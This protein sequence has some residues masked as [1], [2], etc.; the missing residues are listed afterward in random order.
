MKSYVLFLENIGF[1]RLFDTTHLSI[2]LRKSNP[3]Q[4]RKID[5]SIG[6]GEQPVDDFVG[7]VDLL[8]LINEYIVWDKREQ[9]PA[10]DL[11]FGVW[12]SGFGVWDLV[13]GV[14]NLEF[15]V[16]EGGVWVFGFGF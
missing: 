6:N 2:S 13:L 8:K 10:P 12:D 7:R 5:I 9:L 3:P 14:R 15:E 16:S 1:P 4:N 11:G